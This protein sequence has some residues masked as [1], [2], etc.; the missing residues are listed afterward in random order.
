M[1]AGLV[2]RVPSH[3]VRN[4]HEFCACAINLTLQVCVSQAIAK[5]KIVI[6]PNLHDTR[7]EDEQTYM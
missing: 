2:L 3:R 4:G 1:H 6:G 7:S 5:P